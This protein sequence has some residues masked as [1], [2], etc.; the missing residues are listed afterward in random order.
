MPL[1]RKDMQ[2]NNIYKVLI[3]KET[4][5]KVDNYLK[6][7][8]KGDVVA[9]TYLGKSLRNKVFAQLS[10]ETLLE[11]LINTKFPQIFAESAVSGDGSDWNLTE[12][13]ILGDIS[14]AVPVTVYDNGRHSRPEV[15]QPP[16]NAT[17]LYTPGALL[18]NGRRCKPA[19]CAEVV[20]DGQ[21]NYQGFYSLYSRRLLPP[22]IYANNVAKSNKIKALI[23]VPGLGCGCFAGP[24]RGQLGVLLRDVLVDFLSKN[25]QHFSNIRAVYFDPYG[26]CSNQRFE[27]EHLSLLIRP[28]MND[29]EVKSQLCLPEKFEDVAGEFVNCE[30]F[31]LV[32]WDHVSWPGN[33]FYGGS[34]MTDD[35]VKA[36][37]TNSMAVM[38]GV[39]G[40]YNT[41]SNTYEPPGEYGVWRDVITRLGLQIRVRDN[42]FVLP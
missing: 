16:F 29:N 25:I 36:A 40:S 37:A 7:L 2:I 33:D 15:H 4:L 5:A 20:S 13:S 28:L 26:E 9:G 17:L 14:I 22:F 1:D 18:Q 6:E 34:R 21:I 31:S 30:L 19:D 11:L 42:L 3:H 39:E 35:G 32:A 27:L 12:L 38:T 8:M 23:T 24:F 41:A 10:T